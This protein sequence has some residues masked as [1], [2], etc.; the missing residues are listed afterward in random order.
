MRARNR[1]I[2]IFSMSTL[3]VIFGALGAFMILMLSTLTNASSN[4]KMVP[5]DELDD[6]KNAQQ[7]IFAMVQ[8]N[9]KCDVDL[10]VESNGTLHG[11]KP[12]QFPGR[13][14]DHAWRDATAGG[15]ETIAISGTQGTYKV[16][17]RLQACDRPG[18]VPV[19][20][21]IV[22]NSSGSSFTTRFLGFVPLAQVGEMVEVAEVEIDASGEVVSSRLPYWERNS[23]G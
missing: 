10:W 8:W 11:P 15:T 20:G 9:E 2:S 16:F 7:L 18:P 23:G 5:Q 19:N 1:E 22:A 21:W 3:D 14:A 12:A 17:Y 13:A 6:A 4:E